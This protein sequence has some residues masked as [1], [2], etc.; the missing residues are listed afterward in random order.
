MKAI[1]RIGI[2]GLAVALLACFSV[3][4]AGADLPVRGKTPFVLDPFGASTEQ[5]LYIKSLH[6][7]DWMPGDEVFSYQRPGMTYG[8]YSYKFICRRNVNICPD[9]DELPCHVTT[10]GKP[11][12]INGERVILADENT[13]QECVHVEILKRFRGSQHDTLIFE[14]VEQFN[15]TDPLPVPKFPPFSL[16]LP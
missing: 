1:E 9:A 2:Q 3:A 11:D 5:P 15:G 13:S 12:I 7:K 8:Y 6:L 16:K 4:V 10:Y 14:D